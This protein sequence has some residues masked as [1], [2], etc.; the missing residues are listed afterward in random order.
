MNPAREKVPR[1][2]RGEKFPRGKK[3][4]EGVLPR[5]E[6]S[7][8]GESPPRKKVPRGKK[9]LEGESPPREKIPRG[10]KSPE[11]VPRGKKSP[12]G[13]AGKKSF[14]RAG[15][16][17]PRGT[18]SLGGLFPR[19]AGGGLFPQGTPSGDFFPRGLSPSGNFFPAWPCIILFTVYKCFCYTVFL[20]GLFPR[21]T[22][23]GLS[24]SS[25]LPSMLLQN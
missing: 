11:G 9:F 8:G 13:P 24:P 10:K 18:F 16:I 25:L 2:S 17:L 15:L 12:A 14:S 23:G 19:G 5:A 1:G 7:V 21:G 3:S 4:P 22:R 20:G 6:K